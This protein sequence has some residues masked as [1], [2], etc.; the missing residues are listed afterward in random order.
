MTRSLSWSRSW[1][2]TW[3][4]DQDT[5][6]GIKAAVLFPHTHFSDLQWVVKQEIKRVPLTVLLLQEK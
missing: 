3:F 2:K 4:Y 5:A 6:G 1:A